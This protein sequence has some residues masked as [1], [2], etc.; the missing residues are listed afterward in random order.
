[1]MDIREEAA[2]YY[3]L[4]SDFPDDIP[5]YKRLIPA[6]ANVLELGCGTGRITLELAE[7]CG[8]I[9]GIDL[10][11]AM[12][13]ICR[14]RLAQ[15]QFPP[16]KVQVL[17]GDISDFAL[18]R[19]FDWIIAPFRVL[20]NLE[21]DEQVDGLFQ[22]IRSHLAPGGHCVLNVF[23][24]YRD[25]DGLRA[26]WVN[27]EEVFYWENALGE[28]TVVCYGHN[29]RMDADRLVLYPELIYRR[30]LN[31]EK[32]DEAVLKIVMRCYYP[33]SFVELVSAHGFEIVGRWGGYHGEPYGSGPELVLEFKMS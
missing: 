24:P 28:D 12:L 15:A 29:A 13:D 8:F 19:T 10:S 3:D 25:P 22:C 26:S 33:D 2:R 23:H 30:F 27:H 6:G 17:Q 32:L 20:Q 4:N 21:S 1:M 16:T 31:G 11:E 18:G 7:Q 9:Q 5:F 14:K